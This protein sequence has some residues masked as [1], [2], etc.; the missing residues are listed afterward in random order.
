MSIGNYEWHELLPQ[1]ENTYSACLEV[2]YTVHFRENRFSDVAFIHVTARKNI[3]VV[4]SVWSPII[5][6]STEI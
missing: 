3:G 6:V 1:G 5:L 2:V 4:I